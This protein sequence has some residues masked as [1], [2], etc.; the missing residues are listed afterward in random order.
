MCIPVTFFIGETGLPLEVVA[1][2]PPVDEFI[3]KAN[4]AFEVSC[5]SKN[6]HTFPTE[7]Q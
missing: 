3:A 5:S 4:K 1:G 2:S 6:F 7:G